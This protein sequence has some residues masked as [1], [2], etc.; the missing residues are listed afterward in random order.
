MNPKPTVAV[1]ILHRAFMT[2]A[3]LNVA[4]SWWLIL[5]LID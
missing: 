1:V 2:F 5:N 3:A 4:V